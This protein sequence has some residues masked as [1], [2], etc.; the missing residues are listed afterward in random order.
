MLKGRSD[1]CQPQS[2]DLDLG[3]YLFLLQANFYSLSHQHRRGG[4]KIMQGQ[5]PPQPLALCSSNSPGSDPLEYFFSTKF[6]SH[7]LSPPHYCSCLKVSNI[8]H[9]LAHV[10]NNLSVKVYRGHWRGH[11]WPGVIGPRGFRLSF[12][13]HQA[14]LKT[15][16]LYLATPK[17]HSRALC[18]EHA[19]L[20]NGPL[21]YHEGSRSAEAG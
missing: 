14:V 11:S 7:L 20:E 2:S 16:G 10:E 8:F 13:F 1:D 12:R 17:P 15:E 18:L 3:V 4:K 6:F 5:I 19:G 21:R 9:V